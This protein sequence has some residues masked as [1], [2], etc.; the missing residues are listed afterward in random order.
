VIDGQTVEG[1]AAAPHLG[2]DAEG[3]SIGPPTVEHLLLTV[4]QPPQFRI[5]CSEAYQYAHRGTI[6]PYLME[7]ERQNGFDGPIELE[8]GDR[9]NRDLDGIEM[10][11]LV[12]PA[13]QTQG[14]LPIYLP[15][16]MHIN[17]Q[18]QNQLYCQGHAFFD[19]GGGRR[20][21]LFVSEMRC[22]LRSLPTV[23][24]LVAVEP[25]AVVRPGED[26]RC[27]LALERTAN[28]PG[29]MEVHL[30]ESAATAGFT[31]EPVTLPAGAT[32]TEIA[33]HAPADFRG[34]STVLTF[35]GT[36][37]LQSSAPVTST[38]VTEARVMVRGE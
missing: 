23:A 14:F 6:Y 3:A 25:Q 34:P 15:E 13:G 1:V 33:V 32:E 28:F 29:Q 38:V 4:Q 17:I 22:M 19:A 5:F 35:R 30:V 31:A 11:P 37:P 27:C 36:G 2:V 12:I 10:L 21:M 8:I 16:S 7:V 26:F 20:S 9:Q 24:R 18:S